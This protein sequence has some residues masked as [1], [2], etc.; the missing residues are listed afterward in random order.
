MIAWRAVVVMVALA[1]AASKRL[2][3]IHRDEQFVFNNED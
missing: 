2:D 3:N 1:P